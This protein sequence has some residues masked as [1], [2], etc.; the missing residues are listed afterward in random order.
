MVDEVSPPTTASASGW[1]ASEPCSRP[2]AV[3]MRPITVARLVIAMGTKRERAAATMASTS[4]TPSLRRRLASSTSRM[5]FETAMPMTIRMPMSAVIEKPCPAAMSARTMPTSE[6]GM[7][8]SMTKGR[9]SDLNCEAMIMKTT[10]T[11]RPSARP[12]PEKVVRISSTCPTK[13]N[14]MSRVR[15]SC[16]ERAAR[17]PRRRVPMSRPSVCMS[18]WAARWSWLRSTA[19]GPTLRRTSA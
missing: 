14:L 6:T 16:V 5:P 15:G 17:G 10:M 12:R 9:R 8:K 3:G 13:S 1:F 18:T 7:V 19:M 4:A 2:I 11:A